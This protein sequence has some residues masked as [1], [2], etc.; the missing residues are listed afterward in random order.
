MAEIYAFISKHA[1]LIALIWMLIANI[2]AA[3]PRWLTYVALV[4][5]LL[6]APLIV[7]AVI[8]TSGWVIGVPIAALMVFQLRWT[9]YF[10]ARLFN[11]LRGKNAG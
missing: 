1:V 3:G 4:L 8:D 6:T 10:I 9:A 11:T 7:V 2:L 5:M